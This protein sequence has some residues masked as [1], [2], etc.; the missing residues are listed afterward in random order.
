MIYFAA[1]LSAI[2]NMVTLNCMIT[3]R[4]TL[5]LIQREDKFNVGIVGG[6]DF[7]SV[8]EDSKWEQS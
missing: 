6:V 3:G 5:D 8:Q 2:A 7:L 4:T 1:F